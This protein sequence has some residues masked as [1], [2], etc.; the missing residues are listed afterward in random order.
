MPP[1]RWSLVRS[2]APGLV[3]SSL[4][5]LRVVPPSGP[6]QTNVCERVTE[7]CM[8]ESVTNSMAFSP[9][10]TQQGTGSPGGRTKV[11][12]SAGTPWVFFPT[13]GDDSS[14]FPLRGHLVWLVKQYE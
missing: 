11:R 8:G 9:E 3:P 7:S 4:C 12:S 2:R 13:E 14:S 5:C 1:H 6:S 10:D